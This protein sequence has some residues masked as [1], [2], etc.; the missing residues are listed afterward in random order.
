[1]TLAIYKYKLPTNGD[2]V[3]VPKGARVIHC[4]EQRRDFYVW[5]I[6]DTETARREAR[7]FMVLGTGQPFDESDLIHMRHVNTFQSGIFVW[8]VFEWVMS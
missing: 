3:T 5:A 4:A 8:H 1:M 2:P 6:V 7:R